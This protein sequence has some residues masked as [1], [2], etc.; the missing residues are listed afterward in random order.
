M[1][2]PGLLTIAEASSMLR[3]R[4][5]TLRAWILGRRIPY[6]KVGRLVRLRRADV[7]ALIAA[8]VVPARGQK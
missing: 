4:P 2:D 8:S 5:S 1:A 3:L 6:C 7:E